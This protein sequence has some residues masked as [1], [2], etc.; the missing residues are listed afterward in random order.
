[1][2]RHNKG[3]ISF[4]SELFTLIELLVVIAIIAI[5]ASML[6]PALAQA[7]KKA[8]SIKC[9][10]QLKEFGTVFNMYTHDNA[11][12]YPSHYSTAVGCQWTGQTLPYLSGKTEMISSDWAK[13]IYI[14]PADTHMPV[15]SNPGPHRVSYGYNKFMNIHQVTDPNNETYYPWPIISNRIWQ[16]SR[17]L[18]VMCCEYARN[19]ESWQTHDTNGHNNAS[20]LSGSSYHSPTNV[21]MVMVDGSVSVL[22]YSLVSDNTR[23]WNGKF[24]WNRRFLR[25]P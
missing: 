10:S 5:L 23:K 14:C 3:Q 20:R 11:D 21:N 7:R 1:M 6:L 17:M 22:A 24:P 2:S 8:L 12:L 18:M 16:P 4:L 25:N 19:G 9:A 13:S 15:C